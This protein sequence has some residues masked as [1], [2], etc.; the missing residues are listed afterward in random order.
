MF[1]LCWF[2]LIFV[3]FS[4]STGKRELYLLPLY[5]AASLMVGGFLS[6]ITAPKRQMKLPFY[7]LIIPLYAMGGVFI[8]GGLGSC[9]LP[10]VK[11]PFS[12]MVPFFP[13]VAF[14]A[15]VFILGGSVIIIAARKQQILKSFA[16]ATVVLL[17][18]YYGA[19]GVVLPKMNS[20]KSSRPMSESIVRHLPKGKEL[21]SYNLKV[22]PFNFYTG[23]NKIT[24]IPTV[25]ELQKS[26]TA[27]STGLVL[28]KEKDAQALQEKKVIPPAFQIVDTSTIGKTKYILLSRTDG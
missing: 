28:L 1:P 5:P 18:S 6:R 24:E 8:L 9:V 4:I 13:H 3:F 25:E 27:P 11:T 21:V 19:L 22:A 7:T 14:L 26:F 17:V 23:L 20:F 2:V 10:F 12:G 16:G 15:L